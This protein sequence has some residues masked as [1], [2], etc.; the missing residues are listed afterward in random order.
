MII[1]HETPQDYFATEHICRDAFW[2]LYFPG[3]HEHYVL[4]RMRKH[5]DFLPEL[6]FVLEIDGQIAGGIF[7]TRSRIIPR[8]ADTKPV[9][10]VSFGPVFIAPE[11]HRRGLGRMLISHAIEKAKQAGHK[12]ILT[13]GYPYHYSPYGF[14]GGKKYGISMADGKF[15]QGLLALPLQEHAL[16]GI[17]GYVQFSDVFDINPQ[18]AEEYDKKFPPKE[19]LVLPCQAEYEKACTLLDETRY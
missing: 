13:L 12:A 4:H 10:A 11:Y 2:N 14:T 6:S 19:K 16:D 9:P 5:K 15:Y 1:R 7:F 3:A 8:S 18:E 17:S